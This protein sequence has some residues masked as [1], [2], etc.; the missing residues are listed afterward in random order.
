MPSSL[1]TQLISTTRLL[2]AALGGVL[3]AAGLQYVAAWTEPSS[4]PPA[5][6]VG[7]PLTT[8]AQAQTKTGTISINASDSQYL[9]GYGASADKRSIGGRYSEDSEILYIN[10]FNDWVNGVSIGG[11]TYGGGTANFDDVYI[12]SSGEWASDLGGSGDG[13]NSWSC[14]S[15]GYGSLECCKQASN[16]SVSCRSA[17]FT[18]W[19]WSVESASFTP[20]SYPSNSSWPGSIVRGELECTKAQNTTVCCK[21][22]STSSLPQCYANKGSSWG[23]FDQPPF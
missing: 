22:L 15:E 1:S 6:N 2:G 11:N 13:F 21:A 23:V 18:P 19:S 17:S 8:G 20:W 9:A 5:D 16:G 12:R 7:A 3:L 14:D 4:F 10:G